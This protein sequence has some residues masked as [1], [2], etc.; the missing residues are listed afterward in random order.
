VSIFQ[1][2]YNDRLRAWHNLR[3]QMGTVPLS[4]AC[5]LV[6][7][8]WQLAPVIKHHTHPQD[9]QNWPDP[10]AI[11]SE[12][13]YCTLTSA[14]GMCYTILMTH[15]VDIELVS[16]TDGQGE[17]HFLVLVDNAKYILNWWPNS[18]LSTTLREFTVV[19]TLPVSA[20]TTKIKL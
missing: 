6:D 14:I 9:S 7:R 15:D 17:D 4:E 16:A 3:K 1:S 18:V 12:N 10:W 19:Q 13:T 2:S 11:L 8:W 20:L 5:I